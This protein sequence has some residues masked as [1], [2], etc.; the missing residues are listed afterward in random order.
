VGT[1]NLEQVDQPQLGKLDELEA[2][3][4]LDL[5]W[6]RR[7]FAAGMRRVAVG[8]N[9]PV[10]EQRLRPRL[11]WNLPD[12]DIRRQQ[13]GR[14][15]FG[16][17]L[18]PGTN[19]VPFSPREVPTLT[20]P[21]GNRGVGFVSFGLPSALAV[22]PRKASLFWADAV[23]IKGGRTTMTAV[24]APSRWCRMSASSDERSRCPT[25]V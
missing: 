22:R 7:R 5:A 9:P 20:W 10:L 3:G 8:I 4:R 11:E 25:N 12:L 13:L 16:R 14:V 23:S 24:I 6:P 15:V 19:S 17:E 18:P 21:S 1:A 2:V